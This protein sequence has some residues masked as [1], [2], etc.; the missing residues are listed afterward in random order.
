MKIQLDFRSGQAIYEQIAAQIRQAVSTGDLKEGKK[1][2]TVRQLAAELGINFNTV[3]RAYR[4]LDQAGLVST[5]KGRGTYVWTVTSK[6]EL[7]KESL[8]GL[9]RHYVEQARRLSKTPDE[10]ARVLVRYLREWKESNNPPG[11]SG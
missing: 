9:T 3:A 4:M 10:V 2:P 7:W 11:N 6:D 8:D 5:Q 1:L